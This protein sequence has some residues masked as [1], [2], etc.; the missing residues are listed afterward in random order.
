MWPDIAGWPLAGTSN[1]S[2]RYEVCPSVFR[3][4]KERADH[5]HWRCE[6]SWRRD[7]TELYYLAADGSLMAV[8]VTSTPTFE[9]ATP[10]RLF[11]T[12]L[13]TLVNTSITRNQYTASADGRRFLVNQPTGTSASIVVVVNWPAGLK[14]RQ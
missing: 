13:S 6:P 11:Q 3:P 2:G 9:P 1:E 5:D 8:A 4:A 10:T 14:N 7:G 12:N